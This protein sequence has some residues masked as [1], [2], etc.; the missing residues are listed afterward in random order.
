LENSAVALFQR[1]DLHEQF[2]TAKYPHL[3]PLRALTG[4]E[5]VVVM[6]KAHTARPFP[7]PRD[8]SRPGSRYSRSHLQRP[9]AATRNREKPHRQPVFADPETDSYPVISL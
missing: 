2:S 1:I 7:E 6:D 3:N 9:F 5:P 8:A 4:E